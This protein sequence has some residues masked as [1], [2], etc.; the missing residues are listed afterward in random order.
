LKKS[1]AR[2]GGGLLRFQERPEAKS[3]TAR[4]QA[5]GGV[6]SRGLMESYLLSRPGEPRA[7]NTCLRRF[8]VEIRRPPRSGRHAQG[9]HPL[10]TSGGTRGKA[11]RHEQRGL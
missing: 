9:R 10:Q 3:Q 7:K 5:R 4:P 2:S 11:S 8:D 1:R 6:P